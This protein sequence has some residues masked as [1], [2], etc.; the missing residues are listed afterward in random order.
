MNARDML[1]KL[2]WHSD[3]D[4]SKVKVY[5]VHRGAPGDQAM[6]CGGDIIT[7]E[8]SFFHTEESS[9]PY[10]RVFRIDHAGEIVFL[11]P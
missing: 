2:K 10:H 9:I 8:T 7:L 11:R 1:N 5:Y 6:I 3:Y 4:F